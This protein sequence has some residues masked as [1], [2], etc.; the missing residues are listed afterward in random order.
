MNVDGQMSFDD[1]TREPERHVERIENTLARPFIERIYYSRKMPSNVVYSF[2]LYEN[3]ELLGVV[4]YGI[5][6]SPPLCRGLGG[7]TEQA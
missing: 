5:P 7:G 2:G 1:L 4:T 6:A 3:R